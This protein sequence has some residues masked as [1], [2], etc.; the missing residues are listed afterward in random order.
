[1]IIVCERHERHYIENVIE[2]L[3]TENK[4]REK[5]KLSV[6]EPSARS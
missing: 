2:N 1:M 6:D 4:F 5:Q 3:E